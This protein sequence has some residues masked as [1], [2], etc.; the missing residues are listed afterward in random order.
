MRK[1][2]SQVSTPNNRAIGCL[3]SKYELKKFQACIPVNIG[4]HGGIRSPF[5]GLNSYNL[6]CNSYFDIEEK[7]EKI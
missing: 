5:Y 2:S 4:Y 7:L 1:K 3:H 6:P